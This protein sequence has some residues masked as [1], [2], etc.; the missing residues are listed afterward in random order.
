MGLFCRLA[1]ANPSSSF[2]YQA[3]PAWPISKSDSPRSVG[4]GPPLL[5][6]SLSDEKREPFSLA[7]GLGRSGGLDTGDR[8]LSS[9]LVSFPSLFRSS[10]SK[11]FEAALNSS[12]ESEPS[13]LVSNVLTIGWGPECL[14][15]GSWAEEEISKNGE[16][17]NAKI[18]NE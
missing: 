13:L 11:D 10:L 16:N 3:I 14:L 15:G 6:L 2:G 9:S 7:L 17:T 1:S 4:L 8:G 18:I 5:L 12:L